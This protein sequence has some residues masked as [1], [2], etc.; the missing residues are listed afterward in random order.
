[1]KE[2]IGKYQKLISKHDAKA[3]YDPYSWFSEAVTEKIK[4]LD[5][6][7]VKFDPIKDKLSFGE[8]YKKTNWFRFQEAA[9]NYQKRATDKMIPIFCQIEIKEW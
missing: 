9:K 3:E 7:K 5:D 4:F 6:K 2:R 1:M 8:N